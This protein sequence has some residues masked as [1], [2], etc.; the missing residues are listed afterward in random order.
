VEE[1]M[2]LRIK[3]ALAII[4]LMSG[5]IA[6]ATVQAETSPSRA[7]PV[8]ELE[9]ELTD[10]EQELTG[11][12]K[13]ID[14]LLED[15]VDPKITSL[16]VF[17]S[18]QS[19]SGK[20]PVSLQIQLDGELL[21]SKEFVETDRLV[22]IRGGAIE[23]YSGIAEPVSH[24]LS[25]ECFLSSGELQD[26]ITSTG[27]AIFKF[28]ARRAMANFLEISLSQDPANKPTTYKLEARHWSME[29]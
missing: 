9:D 11:L 5:I 19:I 27:K 6:Q 26:G 25:V 22:I 10:I 1:T 8:S 20:V 13:E 3:T 23:V 28:D 18:S 4:L 14:V 2:R 16:S 29:P 17:F 12:E 15:L 7:V 21:T 24:N